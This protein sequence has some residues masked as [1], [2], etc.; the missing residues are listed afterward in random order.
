M[1]EKT[2]NL[3]LNLANSSEA[4]KLV[5]DWIDELTGTNSNSNMQKIDAAYG[6]IDTTLSNHT[7]N[8]NIHITSEEK[9]EWTSKANLVK[10]YF[11]DGDFYKDALKSE[12]ITPSE[13]DIYLDLNTK[14]LYVWDSTEGTYFPVSSNKSEGMT[15]DGGTWG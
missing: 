1:S 2:T 15:I 8:S 12:E 7:G 11:L 9:S 13:L 10:G 3:A 6:E 4:E 14:I 5:A